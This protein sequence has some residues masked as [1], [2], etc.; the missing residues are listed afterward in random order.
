MA[1]KRKS[2]QV[3]TV[4]EDHM[5]VVKDISVS[6]IPLNMVRNIQALNQLQ[7]LGS[8]M[9]GNDHNNNNNKDKDNHK[10]NDNDTWTS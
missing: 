10:D 9:A 1:S 5:N 3:Y 2:I 8:I 6:E 4:R 7:M